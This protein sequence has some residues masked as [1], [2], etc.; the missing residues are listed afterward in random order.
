MDTKIISE[1]QRQDSNLL[2]KIKSNIN[3]STQTVDGH[4]VIMENDRIYM[5][6]IL[7][8]RTLNWYHHFLCHPG[9][10]RMEKTLR[11]TMTWPG[12]TSQVKRC[13]KYCSICQKLKK[14]QKKYGYLPPKEAEDKPWEIV[15]VDLI[16]PYTVKTPSG[17]KSLTTMTMIDPATSW[18]EITVVPEDDKSSAR[19]SQLFNNTWLSR[20][21]RPRYITYDNNSEFKFHF[22]SLCETYGIKRKPT[23]LKNPQA[24]SIIERVHQVLGNMLRTYELDKEDLDPVDPW[25]P[26]LNGVAWA[27]RST[28]HTTLE[29][30]P[31][32]LIY[33]RHMLH[34]LDYLANWERIS[35][36]K[37]QVIDAANVRENKKRVK[38]D[39]KVDDKVL[40][41]K[42]GILRKLESPTEGP[43]TI[44]QVYT[45]GTIRIQRGAVRERMNIRRLS[46]YFE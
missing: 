36:R 2:K 9:R 18:F 45:N 17:H 44:L 39:Y 4:S 34:D 32:S 1:A 29:A 6:T 10:T 20:Y 21:P 11:E 24:N 28:Y 16:G 23:S 5:P 13:C 27:I 19:V 33:G 30:T 42:D 41:H 12:L 40:I 37:Q 15:C 38:H 46:P 31:G 22:K 26:F 35:S 25:G 3:F 43:Y 8:E 14:K 7:Q